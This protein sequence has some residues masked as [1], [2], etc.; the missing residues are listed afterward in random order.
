MEIFEYKENKISVDGLDIF[1]KT[2]GEGK[3]LL[4]LHGW[5]ASSVSWMRVTEDLA[6]KGFEV[7]V[8][9]LPGFGKTP[10]PKEPWTSEN[11][12]SFLL[13]FIKTLKLDDF[14]L[15]GHSFGGGLAL[16]LA[17]GHKAGIA[18]LILCDAAIVREERLDFR[19]KI[20]QILAKIGGKAA[21]KSFLYPFYAKVAYFISGNYDYYKANA[22]MR[23]TFKKV[24]DE[25]LTHLL[26]KVDQ[27]TLVVW[28]EEDRA[29]PLEDAFRISE[30]IKS[31]ELKI[32]TGAGHNPHRTEPEKL[33]G[34]IINFLKK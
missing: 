16:L 34:I 8:P 10:D 32:V 20:S 6:G 11:Y 27:P 19:Q 29:T 17:A 14:Y 2:A 28:G 18:K 30:A 21:S 1:Y 25:D 12:A 24:I 23:E 22:L 33:S 7:I 13:K 4:I 31:S 5:G 9:D 3:P 15:L 26:D